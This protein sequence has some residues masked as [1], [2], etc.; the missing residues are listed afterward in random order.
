[1]CDAIVIIYI[2]RFQEEKWRLET[3]RLQLGVRLENV[4][5]L[6]EIETEYMYKWED[7]WLAE[8]REVLWLEEESL[9]RQIGRTDKQIEREDVCMREVRR[10]FSEY[11]KT[12]SDHVELWENMYDRQVNHIDV[13]VLTL[14]QQLQELDEADNMLREEM[15]K[16]QTSVDAF[17]DRKRERETRAKYIESVI[18]IQAFWRGVMVRKLL[19]PYKDLWKKKRSKKTKKP[20]RKTK[21][22]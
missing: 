9:R 4:K 18:K 22:H 3:N 20:M 14:E 13:D 5:K 12:V 15:D 19:G 6:I 21:K 2:V 1:M 16:L 7:Q 8:N 10:V 11:T 17:E